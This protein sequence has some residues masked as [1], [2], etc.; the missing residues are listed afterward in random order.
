MSTSAETENPT[1]TTAAG[2]EANVEADDNGKLGGFPNVSRTGLRGSRSFLAKLGLGRNKGQKA[3][4]EG[5]GQIFNVGL[6]EWRPTVD[7]QG[8]CLEDYLTLCK[9]VL[10]IGE[11]G[12]TRDVIFVENLST[13]DEDIFDEDDSCV[14]RQDRKFRQIFE[15]AGLKII[16]T[17]LQHG[18]PNE[19]YPVRM[20]GLKPQ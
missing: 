8:D 17:E 7:E 2:S 12:K 6:E 18:F 16:K 11:D 19:L 3:G 20:Y 13:S 14:T 9:T 4:E 15:K 1:A 10:S 5:V